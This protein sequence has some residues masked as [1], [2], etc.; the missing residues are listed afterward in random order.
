MLVK[1]LKQTEI[2]CENMKI[3]YFYIEQEYK[4]VNEIKYFL[5]IYLL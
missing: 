3:I 2:Y 4:E 5:K 1:P